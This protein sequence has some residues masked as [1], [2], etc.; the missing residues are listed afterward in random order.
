MTF[1]AGCG[2]FARAL[3][4]SFLP[5]LENYNFSNEIIR[6]SFVRGY[7]IGSFLNQN[8]LPYAFLMFAV[9]YCGL[10]RTKIK[11]ASALLLLVPIVV[12]FIYTP[13]YP[14]PVHPFKLLFV[15]VAPY[16]LL[17]TSLIVYSF[18]K[19][20][21]PQVRKDRKFVLFV[22]LPPI[23]SQFVWNYTLRM[24]EIDEVWRF[25]SITITVLFL[26][27]MGVATKNGFMGVK[28]KF[29][30]IRLDSTMK[31]MTSGTAVINHSVKN[32]VGKI[33]MLSD[34]IKHFTS[35]EPDLARVANDNE[36]I[37]QLCQHLL[38]MAQRIQNQ[39]Q[40]IVLSESSNRLTTMLEQS[41]Q[42]MH[43]VFES[44]NIKVMTE[45]SICAVLRCDRVHLAETL[46]NVMHN[47]VESMRESG[48]IV[49]T[50]YQTNK[51]IVVA[52]RDNGCGIPETDMQRIFDPFFS[53]KRRENNYGL[54]LSYCYN[55]MR[56][57]EGSIEVISK[58]GEGTTI[59]LNL[60]LDRVE[61][62][63]YSA[64]SGGT[65]YG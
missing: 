1:V 26:I 63:V 19:E 53:N 57:H 39:M 35:V 41:L 49:V 25:N 46:K 40:T 29:E 32:E 11:T 38:D 3:V 65:V 10:F 22:A 33:K 20:S 36:T 54:G 13:L 18:R 45:F 31:A 30:K 23:W 58:E 24:F 8:G 43:P 9:S 56:E 50:T 52:I 59:L 62:L 44:R 60:S 7:A 4:E 12:T 42:H 48:E 15:W 55:V 51:H 28:L 17:G 34:R 64:N 2:G 27:F 61:H 5:F 37:G 16:I 14:V 21:N 6:D 47:A